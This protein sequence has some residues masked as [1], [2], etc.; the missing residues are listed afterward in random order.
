M[1]SSISP[2]SSSAHGLEDQGGSPAVRPQ[3]LIVVID[4]TPSV[5]DFYQAV[6]N[7]P[8]VVVEGSTDPVQGLEMVYKLA[9]DLV[10]L[11]LAMP[12][13]TGLEALRRIKRWNSQTRVVMVTGHYSIETAVEAIR[14]GA[15][16]YICKPISPEKLR[17]LLAQAQQQASSR[18]HTQE[19]EKELTEAFSFR[20]II[21]QT[22]MM[23]EVFDL[24]QRIAPHFRIALIL[25]ETGTG[26]DLI[27]RALHDLSSHQGQRLAICNCA[28]LVD[29][30]AES[31][32][33]GHR[34]GAFTGANEER[35]G[36][37]EW[38]EGGT[39]FLDEVG[40]LSLPIQSKLLRVLE[41]QEIQRLG[42]PQQRKV[43]VLVIAA[44]SRNLERDVKAGRFR[45]DLWY[46]LN[47]LQ[48]KLPPL[49]ERK[50]D[51]PLLCR[52]FVDEASTQYQKH[53]K[54]LSPTA[55]KE[56]RAYSWP[57]NVRE[58]E[59]VI[60]RACILARGEFLELDDLPTVSG[61]PAEQSTGPFSTLEEAEKATLQNALEQTRN[62]ALAARLLGV[63]RATLYRLI[64]KYQLNPRGD[65][66][67]TEK[68][69]D[70]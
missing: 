54:G 40:E 21:G 51:I 56:L 37:F 28:A 26:K 25:G 8:G 69:T 7:K 13:L 41:N 53:I 24:I 38:A 49:R 67:G 48:I 66:E 2:K 50:E 60:G 19:L 62:K 31:Q 17:V 1:S 3:M 45:E 29:T 61:Q 64:D 9:P 16:D 22:P 11:D 34:K 46:R 44:T 65:R 15:A 30:L 63:S 33:F 59:N 70:H 18:T 57:G 39:V 68:P 55:L 12:G 6:M 5:L 42:S 47:M 58:L 32:L 10:I 20:G 43:D 36:L 27:A 52:H 23:Q 14:E 35:V 4:D